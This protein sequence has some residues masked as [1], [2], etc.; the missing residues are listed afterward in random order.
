MGGNAR[1]AAVILS[2]VLLLVI[3]AFLRYMF[4]RKRSDP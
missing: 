1:I 3:A 2:L 4:R